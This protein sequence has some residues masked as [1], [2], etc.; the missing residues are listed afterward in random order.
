MKVR[1]L[2]CIFVTLGLVG[3]LPRNFNT[4]ST[5]SNYYDETHWWGMYSTRT[6]QFLY[7]TQDGKNICVYEDVSD[8]STLSSFSD[9]NREET[10]LAYAKTVFKS[11]K[12]VREHMI[13]V[14]KFNETLSPNL[15]RVVG[16]DLAKTG[17]VVMVSGAFI[18]LGSVVMV[19][20]RPETIVVGKDS[21]MF[22]SVLTTSGMVAGIAGLADVA[23]ASTI[24]RDTGALLNQAK[25]KVDWQSLPAEKRATYLKL[26]H[27]AA[28]RAPSEKDACPNPNTIANAISVQTPQTAPITTPEPKPTSAPSPAAAPNEMVPNM[29]NEVVAPKSE[30]TP[31]TKPS[32]ENLPLPRSPFE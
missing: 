9:F 7:F 3:C 23:R 10:Q 11:A 13:R 1:N 4:A 19:A 6:T 30:S 20:A 29:T 31:A 5:Q 22:G 16:V 27:E 15:A 12:P 24:A 18:T 32:V 14:E 8:P 17:Y 26:I 21:F 25:T 28:L 2:S